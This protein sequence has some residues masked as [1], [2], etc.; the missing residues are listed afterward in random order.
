MR[1][2]IIT[3]LVTAVG[4]TGIG[5][6]Q[7]AI[8]AEYAQKRIN[9]EVSPEGLSLEDAL[10]ALGKSL[11]I[12]I[13][14]KDLPRDRLTISLKERTLADVLSLLSR[15]YGDGL[16]YT[17]LPERAI[18]IAP[19]QAVQAMFPAQKPPAPPPSK[20][21]A[22]SKDE[23]IAQVFTAPKLDKDFLAG[24]KN[25]APQTSLAYSE[26]NGILLLSG[27]PDEVARVSPVLREAVAITQRGQEDKKDPVVVT[28][29]VRLG[30]PLSQDQL[31]AAA[32]VL[33]IEAAL[34]GDSVVLRGGEETVDELARILTSLPP[35]PP[36]PA[37]TK[38]APPVL[39]ILTLPEGREEG[40][41]KAVGALLPDLRVSVVAPGVV[42]VLGPE[43]AI[44]QAV[45][46]AKS[47]PPLPPPPTTS[48]EDNKPDTRDWITKAYPLFGDP[49]GVGK[50]MQ[51]AFP[52]GEIMGTLEVIPQAKSLVVRGPYPLHQAVV[53]LLKEVDPP[54]APT[55]VTVAEEVQATLPLLRIEPDKAGEYLKA[56]GLG[57]RLVPLPTGNQV[58]LIG[59]KDEV[60]RAMN[61][62]QEADRAEPQ[63]RIRV[64]AVQ[65]SKQALSQLQSG[66]GM[67]IDGVSLSLGSNGLSSALSLP[68]SL[69]RSLELNINTLEGKSEARTLINTEV[70]LK[71]GAKSRLN[72]GGSLFVNNTPPSSGSEGGNKEA[73]APSSSSLEYGLVIDLGGKIIPGQP[74]TLDLEVSIQIGDPP[75]QGPVQGSV[76]IAK[77]SLDTSF[78]FR[79]REGVLLGGLIQRTGN[80]SESGVPILSW[81]PFIGDLFKTKKDTTQEEGF[82]LI[83]EGQ[84]ENAPTVLPQ[85]YNQENKNQTPPA[86]STPPEDPRTPPPPPPV[87]EASPKPT[88]K[89]DPHTPPPPPPVTEASPKPT[90]KEDQTRVDDPTHTRMA[91]WAHMSAVWSNGRLGAYIRSTDP[92]AP[93]FRVV[94]AYVQE[95]SGGFVELQPRMRT[96]WI[97][98][99]K[100]EVV[101]LLS[102]GKLKNPY[103]LTLIL[104]DELGERWYIRSLVTLR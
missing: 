17:W 13:F 36:T 91:P 19:R 7:L 72:S 78:R 102:G 67:N 61:L 84:V 47:V 15:V 41:T 76:Q 34:V 80:Q 75:T 82:L 29:T 51:A 69:L 68:L 3:W 42:S 49:E 31:G 52:K 87:T 4:L 38:P 25:L 26:E 94:G 77:R 43:E 74:P 99:Q 22:P 62:L 70:V 98:P 96:E 12:P 65:M 48:K 60:A 14:F 27:P 83:L 30:G 46:L 8:P 85:I 63:A 58:W 11:D 88:T 57:V 16:S 103:D 56:L 89:E 95:A 81:I 66:L 79:D 73:A 71:N 32:K 101:N 10:R 2:V 18:L 50:A 90:T 93:L 54:P 59:K 20:P 5:M 21:T 100:S 37:A 1:R 28:R 92:T 35:P 53:N 44:A 39:K 86:P 9:L 23:Y 104:E 24:L 45:S 64:R 6:A 55:P 40:Y 97:A 33:G